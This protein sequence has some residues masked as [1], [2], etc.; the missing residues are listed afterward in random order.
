MSSNFWP[1]AAVNDQSVARR[2]FVSRSKGSPIL[3]AEV[4]RVEAKRLARALKALNCTVRLADSSEQ[5][6]KLLRNEEFDAGL[7]AVELQIGKDSVLAYLSRLLAMKYLAG[8]G[9]GDDPDAELRARLAGAQ[10]YL[11]RPVTS[12]MLSGLPWISDRNRLR[13]S[14]FGRTRSMPVSAPVQ[15]VSGQQAFPKEV[16]DPEQISS[17][18]LFSLPGLRPGQ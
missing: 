14:S 1:L 12:Q 17:F 6:I 7:V 2:C 16:N 9:S 4:D 13:S 18:S 11:P 3:V 5:V 15:L 10:V 8:V